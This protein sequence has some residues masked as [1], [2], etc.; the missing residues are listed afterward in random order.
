M[1]IALSADGIDLEAKV[2]Q[3]FGTSKYLVIVDLNSGDFFALLG[4][5]GDVARRLQ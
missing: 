1:K 2:A 3:R 5:I 4:L